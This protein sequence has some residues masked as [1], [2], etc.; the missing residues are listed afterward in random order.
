MTT[1]KSKIQNPQPKIIVVGASLGGYE[2]LK[3]VLSAL[4]EDF[5][6][7]LIIVLHRGRD[8]RES[9]AEQLQKAARLPVVEAEDK[10]PVEP[11]RIYLAPADY[12]LLIEKDFGFWI[13]DF[14]L[15]DGRTFG[16]EQRTW[17]KI[18]PKSKI[19]NPKSKIHFALSTEEPVNYARP[20]IDVLFE[21]AAEAYGPGV[22]GIILTG[23]S[24]DGAKGLSVIK[25]RGGRAI[26]QD[27]ITAEAPAMPEAAIKA[28]WVDR[29]MSLEE[30]GKALG[31]LF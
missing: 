16:N 22:T 10:M 21:S 11:G 8:S 27:P 1:R 28:A 12:H 13:L 20:S 15:K 5:P 18:N 9:L 19:P 29:V 31:K 25:H 6:I 3:V 2:A 24:E 14:G 26:V 7:P 4:P 17:G 23:N 30:I